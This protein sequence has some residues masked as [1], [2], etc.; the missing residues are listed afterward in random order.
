MKWKDTMSED[1][2]FNFHNMKMLVNSCNVFVVRNQL[3]P[4][5]L[6]TYSKNVSLRSLR[7]KF[8]FLNFWAHLYPVNLNFQLV[9][10]E[11]IVLQTGKFSPLFS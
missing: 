4:V 8:K 11:H 3:I 1:S 10:S 2:A 9:V 6:V 7:P 5:I